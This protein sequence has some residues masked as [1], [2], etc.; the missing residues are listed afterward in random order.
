[1][2]D[3]RDVETVRTNDDLLFCYMRSFSGD[4]LDTEKTAEQ[5]DTVLK[6]RK[7]IHVNGKHDT[8]VGSEDFYVWVK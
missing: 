4:S 2:Y 7:E 3:P 5:M 8:I 6:F 1:M